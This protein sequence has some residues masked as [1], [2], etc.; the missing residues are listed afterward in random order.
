MN[1]IEFH[2]EAKELVVKYREDYVKDIIFHSRNKAIIDK[3]EIVLK[4]HVLFAI[5]KIYANKEK[6]W[7]D[8]MLNIIGGIFLGTG[9]QGFIN[10]L[11]IPE[12]RIPLLIIYVIMLIIG[13]ICVSVVITS[14]RRRI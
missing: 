6:K 8:E 5:D 9:L 3:D 14:S 7:K 12:I 4:K 13:A 11:G 10:E 1:K 2:Q